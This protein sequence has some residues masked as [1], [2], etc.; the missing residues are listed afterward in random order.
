MQMLCS[1]WTRH[2]H[3]AEEGLAPVVEDNEA[4]SGSYVMVDPMGRL[5]SNATG[6]HRYSEPILSVGVE[7][8][9]EQIIVSEERF[10]GR[11]AVYGWR[12]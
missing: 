2:G 5:F 9:L 4:M 12:R 10:V 3:L 11:G 6:E 8:A 1:A 7:R